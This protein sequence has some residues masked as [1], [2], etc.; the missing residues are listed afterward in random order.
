VVAALIVAALTVAL[1]VVVA[2]PPA[3][4]LSAPSSAVSPWAPD[5]PEFSNHFKYGPVQIQPGQ[6][7]ITFSEGDGRSR[8]RTATS[9][10]STQPANSRT[11]RSRRSM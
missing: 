4:N 6:N 2:A 7:N 9:S 8:P 1:A 11:A 5:Q 10:G 3:P